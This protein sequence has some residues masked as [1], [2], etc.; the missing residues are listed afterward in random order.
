MISEST[1][2]S[3]VLGAALLAA[4]LVL[5]SVQTAYADAPPERGAVSM[6]YLNYQDSQST[7]TPATAGLLTRDRIGVNALSFM[8]K[9]PLAGEWLIEVSFMEDSVTGASPAY[10]SSGFPASKSKVI[11][12]ASGELRHALDLQLTR[13]FP[14]GSVT[15]GTSY[16]SESDYVS[17]SCSLQGTLSSEDKN[18]TVTFGG[19]FNDD[20]INLNKPNVVASKQQLANEKKQ[21]IAGL[22]G[23][24]KVLTKRDIVQL[25]LGYSDGSGYYTDPYKDPDNRPRD[26]NSV[27]VSGR[28]N[29]HVDG[30]DGTVRLSYRYYSDTFGI[31]AHTF[32]AE[33][34]QPLQ[35]GWTVTPILRFYTQS[36]AD[37]YVAVADEK[38]TGDGTPKPPVNV[39]YYTE[40]ERLSAFGAVTFG[41]KVSKQLNQDWSA[42]L[43]FEKYEQ[44]DEWSLNGSGDP[45]LATFHARSIQ[46]GLSRKM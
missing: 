25:N 43:K 37:F 14:E 35:H 22:F 30:T 1:T 2:T 31:R 41:L 13:Y 4:A 20:T 11:S 19:S 45:G 18:T 17:R 44:R 16:S 40:D 34:V 23:V 29:H 42:D 12:G 9:L 27:T 5:P 32:G 39:I 28:W 38:L 15:A 26:R 10:H 36:E 6:K 3:S 21:V 7:D 24:T 33:Y 8:G 46:V